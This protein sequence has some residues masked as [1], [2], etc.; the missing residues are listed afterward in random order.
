M[1]G[2]DTEKQQRLMVITLDELVPKDHLL[3]A[4]EETVDFRFVYL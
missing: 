2:K 3:R 4:I 1:M